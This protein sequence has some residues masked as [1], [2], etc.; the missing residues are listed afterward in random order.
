MVQLAPSIYAADYYRLGEQMQV[1]EEE[2]ISILHLDVMDG[3]FVP[4]FSFGPEFIAKLRPHSTQHFDV[5]LMTKQPQNLIRQCAESGADTI[6]LH[7][8]AFE[9]E[10]SLLNA[11]ESIH[12]FEKKAGIVLNPETELSVLT[13]DLWKKTD[14]LQLMTTRPGRKGQSFLTSSLARFRQAKLTAKQLDAQV[15]LQADGGVNL[16]NIRQLIDSGA[17]TFVVGNGLFTGKL[18]ENIK[19]YQAALT[20]G[21]TGDEAVFYRN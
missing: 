18:R 13:A 20:A 14:K 15:E 11:V 2:G 16:T 17:E 10:K 7:W 19:A 5:H 8:E 12:N 6:L 4:G 9:D 1:M 3:Q 21:R